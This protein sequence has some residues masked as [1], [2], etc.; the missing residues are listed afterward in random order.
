MHNRQAHSAY[1]IGIFFAIFALISWLTFIVVRPVI[2]LLFF[3]LVYS[4]VIWPL[5]KWLLPKLKH[6]R[7][8]TS[9]ATLLASVVGLVVPT[10]FFIQLLV[11]E[12]VSLVNSVRSQYGLSTIPELVEQLNSWLAAVPFVSQSQISSTQ[13]IDFISQNAKPVGDW[14]IN[15]FWT[16]SNVSLGFVIN[17]FLLIILVYFIVPNLPQLKK[18]LVSISPLS[19]DATSQYLLRSHAM[20]MDVIKGTFFIAIAQ[21]LIGGIFL[22]IIGIPTWVLL[23]FAMMILSAIPVLGTGVILVPVGVI[24]ILTGSPIAGVATILWQFLVVGVVDNILRSLLVSK[25]ANVHPAIMMIAVLGGLG[26]FG[27]VGLLYGPLILVVFLT[28]LQVYRL[29][30]HG[31]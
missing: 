11:V 26:A 8:I 29:E 31:E 30:Y 9:L 16:V 15:S 28:T 21:G 3:S 27:P 23:S 1:Q 5:F 2:G 10:I 25:Q 18:Y 14:F 7:S 4:I 12:V 19:K 22:A 17:F 13:I 24:L 20:V 6:H